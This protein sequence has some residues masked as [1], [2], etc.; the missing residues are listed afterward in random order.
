MLV[1]EVVQDFRRRSSSACTKNALASLRISLAL[2]SSL[3]SRSSSFSR[4][5]SVVVMPSRSP[6]SI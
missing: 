6:V 4:Y 3:F 5:S 1:D 2:R